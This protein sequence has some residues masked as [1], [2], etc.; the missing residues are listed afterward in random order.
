MVGA[1]EAPVEG[2]VE[3]PAAGVAAVAKEA[4]PE[5]SLMGDAAGGTSDTS[6]L[7]TEDEAGVGEV[8][9]EEDLFASGTDEDRGAGNKGADDAPANTA[10]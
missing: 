6:E 7:E 9:E 3:V 5:P 8:K 10:G 4:Q 2:A 1:A